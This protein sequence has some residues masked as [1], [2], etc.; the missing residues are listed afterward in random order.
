MNDLCDFQRAGCLRVT[1]GNVRQLSDMRTQL[2][3]KHFASK[4]VSRCRKHDLWFENGTIA[5]D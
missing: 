3:A 1:L 4:F 5:I 2:C